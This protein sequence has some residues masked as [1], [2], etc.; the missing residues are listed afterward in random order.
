MKEARPKI[1]KLHDDE[2]MVKAIEF[3]L[4]KEQLTGCYEYLN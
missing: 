1:F 4:L 2:D 3:D